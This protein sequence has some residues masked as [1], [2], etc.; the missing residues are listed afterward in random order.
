MSVK[1][2]SP[3]RWRVTT[4]L[5]RVRWPR[6]DGLLA[7]ATALLCGG[8]LGRGEFGGSCETWQ[9][10]LLLAEKAG[11]AAGAHSA[12]SAVAVRTGRQA[13]G[14]AA[15]SRCQTLS[16]VIPLFIILVFRITLSVSA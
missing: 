11:S 16:V 1:T 15:G 12:H 13:R 9:P 14:T 3:T 5:V 2:W 10:L 8:S 4:T 7:G 6:C